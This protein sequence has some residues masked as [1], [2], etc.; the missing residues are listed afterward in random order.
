MKKLLLLAAFL[1]VTA[2]PTFAGTITV[3]GVSRT[4]TAAQDAA[5]TARKDANNRALC[6]SKGLT[7]TCT[8]AQFSAAGGVGT[9]YEGASATQNFALDV[10]FNLINEVTAQVAAIERGDAVAAWNA[11][12]AAQRQQAC[13]DLGKS[14]TCQ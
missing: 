14:A 13:I 9:I 5:W 12:T 7:A 10:I 8:Q 4:T 2:A 6:L 3:S 11:A 1:L